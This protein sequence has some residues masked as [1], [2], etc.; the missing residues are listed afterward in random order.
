MV[1]VIHIRH[2][3]PC[4]YDTFSMWNM[5]F[6][7]QFTW[8]TWHLQYISMETWLL[9]AL[10]Q[11]DDAWIK[12]ATLIYWTAYEAILLFDDICSP[13]NLLPPFFV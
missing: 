10:Y 13:M 4:A 3:I 1:P 12:R 7:I 6:T 2:H 5:T 11:H 9:P 8:E